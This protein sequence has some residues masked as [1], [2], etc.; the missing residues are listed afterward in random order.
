VSSIVKD[1]G[2]I[3]LALGAGL[4][5]VA[6][7]DNVA[8]SRSSAPGGIIVDVTSL[9]VKD[10]FKSRSLQ[11]IAIMTRPRSADSDRRHT[12]RRR[13]FAMVQL[14]RASST[15]TALDLE[16]G[17]A[18]LQARREP[19]TRASDA[20]KPSPSSPTPTRSPQPNASALAVGLAA[21]LA[22][23]ARSVRRRLSG[24]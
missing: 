3:F 15:S 13:V 4:A 2:P 10:S 22:E 23:S 17:L 1:A 20:P 24:G 11:G 21:S 19:R 7:K 9:D 16:E 14:G 12:T 5:T 8:R 6:R 18:L